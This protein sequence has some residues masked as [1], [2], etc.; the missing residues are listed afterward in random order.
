MHCKKCLVGGRVQGVFYRA[1]AARRAQELQLHG[2]AR[3]LP[4]GRVEVLACG[5]EPALSTFVDW[6][7]QGSSASKV[8]S[9]EV[10][11]LPAE[12]L[13]RTRILHRLNSMAHRFLP[14]ALLAALSLALGARPPGRRGGAAGAAGPGSRHR[15]PR[16]PR[17]S[18][19]P[20][21]SR[22]R[23][24]LRRHRPRRR[25]GRPCRPRRRRQCL[26]VPRNPRRCPRARR[27]R[28]PRPPPRRFL[29]PQS[30][31]AWVSAANPLAV[32]AGLQI[33]DKGGSALDAAVAVQ[34]M[35]G[36]VEPQSSGVGG[37]GFLLYYDART[38]QG[39]CASTGAS[40]RRW[41]RRRTCSCGTASRCRT[42][43]RCA[44]AAR[45]ACRGSSPC[46]TP[47]ARRTRCCAGRICLSRR[48]AR[49]PT[50][51]A[52]RR[53]WRCSSG[54]D[55]RFRPRPRSATCSR[56]RTGR[57]SRKATCSATPTMR[58]PSGASPRKDRARST[59]ARSPRRSCASRTSSRCPG[60]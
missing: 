28:P 47:R 54:R 42:W 17:H 39:E 21:P 52:C 32:E 6:L 40:A 13:D 34:A 2:Y 7:W 55:R 29:T 41:G 20:H 19:P 56:A 18:R 50:A 11:D 43:R 45:P 12:A 51:S 53:A 9:V 4:D 5:E 35:L 31:Q 30:H 36:L 14:G 15:R 59:R 44:A 60:R 23:P 8:T 25:P 57:T 38:R 26:K 27:P 37:G 58:R 24:R 46:C 33:L 16:R 49:P 1:S 3:N 22:R 48:S 10:T